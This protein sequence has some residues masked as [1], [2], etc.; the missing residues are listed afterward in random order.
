[1]INGRLIL[2]NKGLGYHY[3]GPWVKSSNLWKHLPPLKIRPFALAWEEPRWGAYHWE[4]QRLNLPFF[5]LEGGKEKENTFE[6]VEKHHISGFEVI[7]FQIL[8]FCLYEIDWNDH[9]LCVFIKLGK[10]KAA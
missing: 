10:G 5:F 8:A 3:R 9:Q 7:N 6:S 2:Q 1:M 4:A